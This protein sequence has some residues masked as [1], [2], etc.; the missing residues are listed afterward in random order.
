MARAYN[1]YGEAHA[2]LDLA[3]R[4]FTAGLNSKFQYQQTE[5]LEAAA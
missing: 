2:M 4:R 3:Q 5:S 1:D